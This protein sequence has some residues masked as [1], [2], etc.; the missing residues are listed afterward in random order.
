MEIVTLLAR[1]R[2]RTGRDWQTGVGET[3]QGKTSRANYAWARETGG[4][5][6]LD[7]GLW[8]GCGLS[9]KCRVESRRVQRSAAR[10]SE[11]QLKA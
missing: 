7:F 8:G 5:G 11:V 6:T 3:E 1:C 4:R 10:C 2:E 9:S